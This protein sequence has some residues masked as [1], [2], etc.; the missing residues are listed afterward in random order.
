MH[1]TGLRVPPS[2]TLGWSGR[3][4]DRLCE[5]FVRGWE[6]PSGTSREPTQ[7]RSTYPSSGTTV[8]DVRSLDFAVY[9]LVHL[10]TR[11]GRQ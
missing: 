5:R 3:M 4:C 2:I 7:P 9:V 6:P 8:G 11:R 10:E 1:V